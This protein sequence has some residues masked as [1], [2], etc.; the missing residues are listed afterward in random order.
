MLVSVLAFGAGCWL[1]QQWSVLPSPLMLAFLLAVVLV[2][3]YY[4]FRRIVYVFLGVIWTSTIAYQHLDNVLKPELQGQEFLIQGIVSGLPNYSAR[5]VRFDFKVTQA[6]VQLPDKMRLSWYY[7]KQKMRAGQHWQFIVKLKLPHGSLNPGSF[8]YE[9]WLFQNDIGATGYV[10]QEAKAKLL[11]ESSKMLNISVWRQYLTE[12][13]SRQ[14]LSPD[15]LALIKALTLADKSLIS[16]QQW[17]VLSDSG[18]NHL[19]AISGLHIGLVA[20]MAYW[21]AFYCWLRVPSYKYCAPQVA[22]V[23]SF[24]AAFIYAALAGFSVPTQR[25]LVMLAVLV[26]ATLLRRHVQ[27]LN[28]FAIALL[29]V[30][31][32]DPL[33]VLSAGFYLSFLAVFFII[34]TVSARLG[35]GNRWLKSIKLHAVIGLSLMPILLLFFQSVSLITPVANIIAVPVIS[36]IIVPLAL[37]ALLILPLLPEF[38]L[39]ILQL[40]DF[41]LQALWQVLLVLVDFPS[42]S[43]VRPQ[44]ELWKTFVALFGVLLLLAPKGIPGRYLGLLLLMPLFMVV[45]EKR[46]PVGEASIVLLDVGQ[47]LAVVVQ[48]AE[49]TLLF[50]TGAKFSEEFDMG[51]N[52]VLPFLHYQ[53]ITH[54]DSL[55]IS[56]GD[57]DHIGGAESVL[58]NMPTRQ[59]LTSVPELL[60]AYNPIACHTGQHWRWDQVIFRI[61][62]PP[63]QAFNNENDN[64]CVVHIETQQGSYLLTGDIEQ[65][66]EVYLIASDVSIQADVL[67]APHHG[68]K[69][70]SNMTFLEKVK[71]SII[72]IPA[73]IPNRFRFPHAEVL[74]RYAQNKV[75][76]LV[77]GEQGAITVKFVD[78]KVS[79]ENYRASHSHY[80]NR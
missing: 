27:A 72:L 78:G 23:F 65:A 10:R 38:A 13:L 48:T 54:L 19:M 17:Q 61:L 1:V 47:G 62:S 43:I 12:L 67:I 41:S 56:H 55:I 39:L 69:T 5:R 35:Q 71:P 74:A 49:H 77:T 9:K 22:A 64:S 3:A 60:Q 2:L 68:S 37:L 40:V 46:P 11:A 28:V 59:V 36:F 42:A 32:F 58:Q 52:V 44:P 21:L 50:D 25:A 73:A 6:E 16:R 26:V 15:S 53:G 33:V 4:K 63:K 24:V 57:N 7:P 29:V 34:Y 8:D 66:A 18:T 51:R 70:S 79:I 76:F 20:S 45:N 30:L 31:L 75:P 14:A 80:W